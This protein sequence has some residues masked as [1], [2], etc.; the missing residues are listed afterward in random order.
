MLTKDEITFAGAYQTNNSTYYLN[1]NAT[2][3]YWW[4]LSPAYFDVNYATVYSYFVVGTGLL[5]EDYVNYN[6]SAT[7][8]IRPTIS[9]IVGTQ[10]TSGD[11]TVNNAY[12][13]K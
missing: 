6:I 11:G 12:V 9:L 5:C 4:A 2:S 13:V 3:G 10:I 8:S 1:K 7:F